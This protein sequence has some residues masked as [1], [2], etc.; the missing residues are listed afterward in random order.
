MS[1][2]IIKTS[3]LT[4]CFILIFFLVSLPLNASAYDI[5]INTSPKEDEYIIPHSATEKL[6]IVDLREL[7]IKII[8]FAKN[9]IYARHGLIF[10]HESMNNYFIKKTWYKADNKFHKDLLNYT[11]ASNVRLLE[12]VMY[13][14]RKLKDADIRLLPENVS[15]DKAKAIESG[16]PKSDNSKSETASEIESLIKSFRASA[17]EEQQIADNVR[18]SV[19]PKNDVKVSAKQ[20]LPVIKIENQQNSGDLIVSTA[21]TQI[22]KPYKYASSN[23]EKGFDCSGLVNWVYRQHGIST[24]RSTPDLLKIGTKVLPNQLKPG[25]IVITKHV[26]SRS[27]PNGLHAGIYVGNGVMIH[28]PGKNRRVIEVKMTYFNVQEGRR[29][30]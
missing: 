5:R 13:D 9:E 25:D 6:N 11:E 22:G 2:Y 8:E 7:D 21:R 14:Y 24:P 29:L 16:K 18:K 30:I 23:P 17:L 28:A 12:Q 1:S 3:S 10:Q 20:S 27:T 15:A 19:Q 26:R 4:I